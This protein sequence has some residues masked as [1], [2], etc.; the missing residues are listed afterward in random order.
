MFYRKHIY[1]FLEPGEDARK[2]RPI[3]AK[4]HKQML[5]EFQVDD[6]T[7]RVLGLKRDSKAEPVWL[8]QV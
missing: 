2:M 1:S 6:N 5:L 8:A 4:D 7:D 3:C